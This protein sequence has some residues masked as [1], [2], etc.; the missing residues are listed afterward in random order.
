MTDLGKDDSGH[1]GMHAGTEARTGEEETSS[2]LAQMV[3]A[4]VRNDEGFTPGEV[5][6]YTN[7][8]IRDEAAALWGRRTSPH[9][10][11]RSVDSRNDA[12]QTRERHRSEKAIA[13][14]QHYDSG[15]IEMARVLIYLRGQR[16]ELEPQTCEWIVRLDHDGMMSRQLGVDAASLAEPQH[17]QEGTALHPHVG[18]GG[19]GVDYSRDV[20]DATRPS[21]RAPERQRDRAIVASEAVARYERGVNGPT[22][23]QDVVDA[24]A[25][26]GCSTRQVQPGQ[27]RVQ[28]REDGPSMG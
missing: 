3:Q 2:G 12:R 8:A 27:K 19:S 1:I 22:S 28:A 13:F 5:C 15:R 20:V 17:E 24:A 9:H 18:G 16:L 7:R 26:A 10:E 6:R 23:E 21:V 11:A 25:D 4:F 14:G